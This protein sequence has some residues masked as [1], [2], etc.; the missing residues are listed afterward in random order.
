M[1]YG[2]TFNTTQLSWPGSDYPCGSWWSHGSEQTPWR[3]NSLDISEQKG[4]LAA[5]LDA[6]K[7]RECVWRMDRVND[8]RN[9][10]WKSELYSNGDYCSTKRGVAAAFCPEYTSIWQYASLKFPEAL[11]QGVRLLW[12]GLMVKRS[13]SERQKPRKRTLNSHSTTGAS[14]PRAHVS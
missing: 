10:A 1:K 11:L 2:S 6:C 12:R 14:P 5:G 8:A 3:L 9:E 4:T 7:C 13:T